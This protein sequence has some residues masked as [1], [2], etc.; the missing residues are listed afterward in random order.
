M[1][2]EKH[3]M[4]SSWGKKNLTCS[5][6][7]WLTAAPSFMAARSTPGR[8]EYSTAKDWIR[9]WESS[10]AFKLLAKTWS[11]I[12]RSAR[13][14]RH[15]QNAQRLQ[16]LLLALYSHRKWLSSHLRVRVQFLEFPCLSRWLTVSFAINGHVQ[17]TDAHISLKTN[18][19]RLQ[20]T[21]HVARWKHTATGN[22][23]FR[24]SH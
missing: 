24:R 7:A 17:S 20:T 3:V 19:F 5:K 11:L 2:W 1:V 22:P 18:V 8:I 23:K 15:Q 6:A 9:H 21:D 4:S 12:R 13:S 16:E 10:F 14:T